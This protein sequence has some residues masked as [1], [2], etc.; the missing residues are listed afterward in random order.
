VS[1][2]AV[3]DAIR[4]RFPGAVGDGNARAAQ[5]AHDHVRASMRRLADA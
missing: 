5:A 4:E 2:A 3:C 1:L